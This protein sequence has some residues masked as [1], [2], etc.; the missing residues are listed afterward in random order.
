MK[1]FNIHF[2]VFIGFAIAL[3]GIGFFLY[4]T[5]I[6][7][8]LSITDSQQINHELKIMKLSE[9]MMMGVQDMESSY[10]GY[11]I[12]GDTSYLKSA[13]EAFKSLPENLFELNNV[14]REDSDQFRISMELSNAINSKID[15]AKD[16]IE[17]RKQNK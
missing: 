16:I 15:F 1:L 6:N 12:T 14:T 13:N 5:Y 11:V 4:T 9:N 3:A 8:Q 2:K 10:R 7:S 17:K